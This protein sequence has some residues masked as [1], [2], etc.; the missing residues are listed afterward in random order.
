MRKTKKQL[1]LEEVME[2]KFEQ[3]IEFCKMAHF[4]KTNAAFGGNGITKADLLRKGVSEEVF[5]WLVANHYC[6]QQ[7]AGKP[8][9]IAINGNKFYPSQTVQNL[10]ISL[11]AF[12]AIHTK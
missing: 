11:A 5:T 2:S 6:N 8:L 1:R 7:K 4:A 3:L 10:E 9:W 12:E